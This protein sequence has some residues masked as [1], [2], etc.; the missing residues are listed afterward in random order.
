MGVFRFLAAKKL[1]NIRLRL[2]VDLMKSAQSDRRFIARF[3][4]E[5]FFKNV[6]VGTRKLAASDVFL[7]YSGEGANQYINIKSKPV[8]IAAIA[9]YS[10]ASKGLELS[11]IY[12]IEKIFPTQEGAWHIR[13]KDNLKI[14]ASNEFMSILRSADFDA[15]ISMLAQMGLALLRIE[16]PKI[17]LSEVKALADNYTLYAGIANIGAAY[18]SITKDESIT[19]RMLSKRLGADFDR[20]MKTAELFLRYDKVASLCNSVALLEKDKNFEISEL[21]GCADVIALQEKT[22]GLKNMSE[23][24]FR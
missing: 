11:D 20:V 13:G 23:V 15:T 24:K 12:S 1:V 5:L 4:E 19:L 22:G 8:Q 16:L 2:L 3:N 7:F 6:V 14:E 18:I 9:L 10:I 21:E 17:D